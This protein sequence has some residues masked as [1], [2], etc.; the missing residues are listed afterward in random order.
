M[1]KGQKLYCGN[2]P[3]FSGQRQMNTEV[4]TLQINP[5][6][7]NMEPAVTFTQWVPREFVVASVSS[8]KV[9]AALTTVQISMVIYLP[10]NY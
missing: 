3:Q 4:K 2:S 5:N 7:F 10:D 9:L 8:R 6:L 1:K